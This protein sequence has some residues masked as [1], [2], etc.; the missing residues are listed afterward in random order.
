MSLR[1]PAQLR[2]AAPVTT[3]RQAAATQILAAWKADGKPE[4]V[5]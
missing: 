4:V 5:S 1:R 3:T 2:D